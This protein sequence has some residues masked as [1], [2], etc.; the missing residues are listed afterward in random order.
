MKTKSKIPLYFIIGSISILLNGCA[1][2]ETSIKPKLP[3]FKIIDRIPN[4]TVYENQDG[5]LNKDEATKMYS[6]IYKLRVKENYSDKTLIGYNEFAKKWNGGDTT[7][8]N[9][10]Q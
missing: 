2:T 5:S 8:G 3:V 6:T 10:T 1:G 9:T 4:Q 7:D